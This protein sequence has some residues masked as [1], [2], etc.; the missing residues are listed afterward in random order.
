VLFGLTARAKM[1]SDPEA[2]VERYAPEFDK[3]PW[4]VLMA[5][6]PGDE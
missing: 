3:L 5:R 6:W 1:C 4:L 2:V